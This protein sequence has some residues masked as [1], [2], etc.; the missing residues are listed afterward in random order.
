[1]AINK[2]VN[3]SMKMQ[4]LR[5]GQIINVYCMLFTRCKSNTKWLTGEDKNIR[6]GKRDQEDTYKMQEWQY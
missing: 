5:L 6:L 2:R 1:M 3:P 4:T